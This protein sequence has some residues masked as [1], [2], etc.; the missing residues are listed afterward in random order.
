MKADVVKRLHL[1]HDRNRT[2]EQIDS[3]LFFQGVGIARLKKD[4]SGPAGCLPS[5]QGFTIGHAP[6]MLQ[7]C[8][9]SI[10]VVMLG[11]T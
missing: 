6:H 7:D 10:P 1:L 11:A 8:L 2:V 5:V 3:L 4:R 9:S